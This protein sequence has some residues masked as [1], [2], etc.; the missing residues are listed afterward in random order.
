MP[1]LQDSSKGLTFLRTL[2]RSPEKACLVRSFA[3]RFKEAHDHH[4]ELCRLL[5]AVLPKM[6]GLKTLLIEASDNYDGNLLLAALRYR[7][8]APE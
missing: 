1:K 4:Q 5:C 2:Q 7:C 6:S 8:L 3:F